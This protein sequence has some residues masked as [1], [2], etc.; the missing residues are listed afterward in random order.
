MF[1]G[2][3]TREGYERVYKPYGEQGAGYY[4]APLSK[5]TQ[6]R[7]S[8][9]PQEATGYA[10]GDTPNLVGM[11]KGKPPVEAV[12]PVKSRFPVRSTPDDVK[13]KTEKPIPPIKSRKAGFYEKLTDAEVL[14]FLRDEPKNGFVVR[15]VMSRSKEAGFRSPTSWVTSIEKKI[16]AQNAAKREAV[17]S[18]QERTSFTPKEATGYASGEA[19]NLVGMAKGKPPVEAVKPGRVTNPDLLRELSIAQDRLNAIKTPEMSRNSNGKLKPFYYENAVAVKRKLEDLR[20]RVGP[21]EWK[22]LDDAYADVVNEI[23]N[24]APRNTTQ[25]V[26]K[27]PAAPKQKQEVTLQASDSTLKGIEESVNKFYYSDGDFK[28]VADGDGYK[29]TKRGEVIQGV[30]VTKKGD[31]FRFESV[32]EPQSPQEPPAAPSKGV[33]AKG[34]EPWEMTVKEF[35]ES[36]IAIKYKDYKTSNGW[37][38]N[39]L[40]THM[41]LVNLARLEGKP[42][43]AEVLADYPDLVAKVAPTARQAKGVA[44]VSD[45]LE[46]T[47]TNQFEGSVNQARKRLDDLNKQKTLFLQTYKADGG[48]HLAK[49]KLDTAIGNAR[50]DLDAEVR[51]YNKRNAELGLPPIKAPAAGKTVVT[52]RQ[53]K[54]AKLKETFQKFS[55]EDVIIGVKQ[56]KNR[57]SIARINPEKVKLLRQLAK[58]A[59]EYGIATLD[60]FVDYV[61]GMVD[62]ASDQTKKIFKVAAKQVWE[63]EK[64][65]A[66]PV[67]K[68]ESTPKA[69]PDRVVVNR[70]AK[71]GQ[72]LRQAD[73]KLLRESLG[74]D[75]LAKTPK[76]LEKLVTEIRDSGMIDRA[77]DIANDV[78]LNPRPMSDTETAAVLVRFQETV[79]ELDAK[80]ADLAKAVEANSV[81]ETLRLSDEVTALQNRAYVLAD[82][83][84]KAGSEWGRAGRARQLLA[85]KGYSNVELNYRAIVANKKALSPAQLAE[86]RELSSR[87]ESLQKQYDESQTMAAKL[88]DENAKLIEDLK[89]KSVLEAVSNR[90]GT[91]RRRGRPTAQAEAEASKRVAEAWKKVLSGNSGAVG[92]MF[93]GL[94]GPASAIFKNSPELANALRDLIVIKLRR[95]GAKSWNKDVYDEIRSILPEGLTEKLALEDR[96]IRDILIRAY[97]EVPTGRTDAARQIT[98]LQQQAK[99]L[100]EIDDVRAGKSV[101]AAKARRAAS[102]EVQALRKELDELK[103]PDKE[104]ARTKATLEKRINTLN[105]EIALLKKGDEIAKKPRSAKNPQVAKLEAERNRLQR[106]RKLEAEIKARED[107]TYQKPGSKPVADEVPDSELRE[108]Q[109]KL[110][111]LR[112][113]ERDAAKKQR[114]EDEIQALE[115]MKARQYRTVKAPKKP[116]TYGEL[117]ERKRLLRQDMAI[118]DRIA[119]LKE[120]VRTRTFKKEDPKVTAATK[121][122]DEYVNSP[123]RLKLNRDLRVAKSEADAWVKHLAEKAKRDKMIPAER[124]F[125]DAID[126]TGLPRAIMASSDISAPLRQGAVMIVTQPKASMRALGRMFGAIKSDAKMAEIESLIISKYEESGRYADMLDGKLAIQGADQGGIHPTHEDFA[127]KL[128]DVKVGGIRPFGII[129]TSERAMVTFLNSVR[130]DAFDKLATALEADGVKLTKEEMQGIAYYVNIST[131]AGN[132][133]PLGKVAPV[134]SKL[135]FAPSFWASRIQYLIGMPIKNAGSSRVR[136]QIAKEYAKFYSFASVVLGLAAINGWTTA[137]ARD[138]GFGDLKLSNQVP[139]E[140]K[141][142]L[143]MMLNIVGASASNELGRVDVTGG[144]GT[145]VT[146]LTRMTLPFV[147]GLTGQKVA[148]MVTVTG[149]ER[150]SSNNAT[151]SYLRSRLAPI[152]GLAVT[153]ANRDEETGMPKNVIGQKMDADDM[154]RTMLMP[155]TFSQLYEDLGLPGSPKKEPFG[156]A[157][158]ENSVAPTTTDFSN[159]TNEELAKIAAGAN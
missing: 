91:S 7:A 126:A 76:K 128:I 61:G 130:M 23:G 6:P 32:K 157:K 105:R 111:K 14:K 45:R 41:E 27:P 137:D 59:A 12:K 92:S 97:D 143:V 8:F 82:A 9:T 151:L 65:K 136:M 72:S 139:P 67:A 73:T 37:V 87:I 39:T 101:S 42:V 10:S 38:G 77:E 123:E 33:E 57:G 158:K 43:P 80:T 93:G 142:Y 112:D 31:R 113:M 141:P 144:L 16:D 24:Q 70:D 74:K 104:A 78:I 122:R 18:P 149:E 62:S 25:R 99:L 28:V 83:S 85:K 138:S 120:Q 155:L 131:G 1:E 21:F 110:S 150:K 147:A 17:K 15:Q 117:T 47:T 94:E 35:R 146:A 34:K 48:D 50:N 89:V 95:M 153:L 40:Q 119:N 20:D 127:T 5:P 69:T 114:I 125:W 107:G 19:P 145:H 159:M 46:S 4:D 98:A 54:G 51:A 121:L 108:L 106:V 90:T 79:G 68:T 3:A 156:S 100:N 30:R 88:Q 75:P 81:A 134:M 86:Q 109:G 132:I 29:I 53:A 133:A 115:D 64:G 129:K 2:N 148:P 116:I 60:E 96:D 66:T 154:A 84:D 36:P 55:D 102:P 11:A 63:A 56:G 71:E 58:D 22:E 124:I 49:L 26:A 44:G 152:P 118:Q 135:F 13:P 103:R 140:V 52:P